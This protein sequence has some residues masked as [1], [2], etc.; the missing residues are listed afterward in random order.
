MS[1]DDN[2]RVEVEIWVTSVLEDEDGKLKVRTHD[3]ST[4]EVL[5]IE[6]YDLTAELDWSIN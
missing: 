2:L 5:N 1:F 4:V 6:S 3:I